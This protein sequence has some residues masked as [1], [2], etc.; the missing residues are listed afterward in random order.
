MDLIDSTKLAFETIEFPVYFHEELQVVKDS[1]G[2]IIC[3]FDIM[4]WGKMSFKTDTENRK[5]AMGKLTAK[6]L[7][8]FR[9]DQI[10]NSRQDLT[11]V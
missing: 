9:E 11:L 8:D 3:D 1:K 2:M 5:A 10:K 4:G 6:I 7:N